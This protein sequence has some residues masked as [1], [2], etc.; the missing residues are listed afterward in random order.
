MGEVL[1]EWDLEID[2][3]GEIGE[4]EVRMS[5]EFLNWSFGWEVVL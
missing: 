3:G 2:G 1:R 4:V 5:L